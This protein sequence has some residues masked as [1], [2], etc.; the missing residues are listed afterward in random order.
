VSD[1][2][3]FDELLANELPGQ[4]PLKVDDL[5]AKLSPEAAAKVRERLLDLSIPQAPLGRALARAAGADS[6]GAH[7]VKLWRERHANEIHGLMDGTS[8]SDDSQ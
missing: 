3:D 5:M 7:S 6:C 2:P 4:G 1:T 8:D